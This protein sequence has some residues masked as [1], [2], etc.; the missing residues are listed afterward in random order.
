MKRRLPA[1]LLALT[2]ALG[3]TVPALAAGKEDKDDFVISGG[4]LWEYRGTGGHVTI[5][6]G[7]TAICSGA[8]DQCTTLSSVTIP[9]GVTYI[10]I[11]AFRSCVSL[12]RVSFPSTLEEIDSG[13][14]YG[15]IRLASVELP[16]S[17]VKLGERGSIFAGCTGLQRV[18][19]GRGLTSLPHGTFHNCTSLL[20]VT[21]P[22]NVVSFTWPFT[23]CPN[24]TLYG[25]AGSPAQTYAAQMGLR[26]SAAGASGGGL[27]RFSDVSPKSPYAAGILWGVTYGI[28]S[29][30]SRTTFSPDAPCTAGQMLTFLWRVNGSPKANKADLFDTAIPE[31][32]RQAVLW[33][34]EASLVDDL[35]MNFYQTCTRRQAISW[36][37]KL[38]GSPPAFPV[39]F[40]DVSEG[41]V[42][43]IPACWAVNN[44]VMEEPADLRFSPNASCTRGQALTYLYQATKQSVPAPEAVGERL[45][46]VDPG[47]V[48]R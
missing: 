41:G 16:D 43:Y 9:A 21:I 38:A 29:G 1:L 31:G 37:W 27:D 33:A 15:C 10:G 40:K 13:A 47:Q 20:A 14:F 11:H 23:G 4:M 26:F 34:Y 7:V 18:T 24:V 30:T 48:V 17:V 28:T 46:V 25:S 19:L 44:G 36:L 32:Y 3:L 8:F 2:L 35:T 42:D 22:D 39:D 12:S 45:L 5:P 6:Q